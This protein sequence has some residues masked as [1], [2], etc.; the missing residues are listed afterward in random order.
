MKITL[1]FFCL[2]FCFV[3]SV[4][5][6]CD[7]HFMTHDVSGASF[8]DK[9]GQL[10]GEEGKG[11][12][13]YLLELVIETL[14]V[15]GCTDSSINTIP[16]PRGLK[17]V[18]TEDNNALFNVAR[19]RSREQTV[20]WI[21]PL[22]N[23]RVDFYRS[24]NKP[25]VTSLEEAREVKAIGV[26]LGA[27]DNAFLQSLG[28]ANLY[29]VPT[30]GHALK[31]LAKGRL[32][33]VPAGN[34]VVKPLMKQFDIAPDAIVRT[35]LKLSDTVGYIAVSQNVSDDIIKKLQDA[36]DKVKDSPLNQELIEKYLIV[37]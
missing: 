32:D 12:R 29:E 37:R 5:S 3:A 17:M 21:G 6:A 13:S 20:K 25:D 1:F 23:G 36:L 19:A 4:S 7:L 18:Q 26:Q 31:M 16:F 27:G 30:Q 33:L 24:A 22:Y 15:A 35:S 14:A 11:L 34:L 9:N 10:R 2:V 8:I 28:F